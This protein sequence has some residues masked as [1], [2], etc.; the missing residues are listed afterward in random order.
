MTLF[1]GGL[2]NNVDPFFGIVLYFWEWFFSLLLIVVTHVLLWHLW[3]RP[4]APFHGLYWA[5][6]DSTNA[7]FIADK[8]LVAEMVP[9]RLAK[10]IFDYSKDEYELDIPWAD[11]PVIGAITRKIWT[12]AF[13]YPTRYLPNIDPITALVFKIGHVNKDVEIAI[14]RQNGEWER[15]PS[16]IC[17][18]VPVDIV[19]DTD[20]WTLPNSKQHLA[21]VKSAREWNKNHPDDQVHSYTKYQKYLIEGNK[22]GEKITCPPEIKQEFLVPWTRI[23][24][25]FPMDLEESDW[26]GKR[27]QMAADKQRDKDQADKRQMALVIAVVGLGFAGLVVFLKAI[28]YILTYKPT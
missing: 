25:G 27:R 8:N 12:F 13:Y 4:H 24:I 26:A 10:C 22:T 9:E 11:K 2:F 17:G 6:K 23:E 16:V 15:Y 28:I 18:G 1:L 21:I 20:N 14:S 5:W 3:W 7:A 19:I